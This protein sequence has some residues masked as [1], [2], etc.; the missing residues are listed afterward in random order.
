MFC[1]IQNHT[2]GPTPSKSGPGKQG[3][4]RSLTSLE[5]NRARN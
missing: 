1:E 4:F 3:R 5:A 2:V